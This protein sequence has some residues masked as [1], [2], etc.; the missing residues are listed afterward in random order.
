MQRR[1]HVVR[2]EDLAHVP[3]GLLEMLGEAV[4][5]ADEE[6]DTGG[7][8]AFGVLVPAPQPATRTTASETD[9][10]RMRFMPGS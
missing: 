8:S 5:G 6:G 4:V 7:G 2:C 1:R 3:D 10:T 9:A